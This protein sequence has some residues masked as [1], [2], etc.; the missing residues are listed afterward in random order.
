MYRDDLFFSHTTAHLII[1]I[2][3]WTMSMIVAMI[4]AIVITLRMIMDVAMAWA[5]VSAFA[6]I[7]FSNVVLL[8]T[9][10]DI[11]QLHFVMCVALPWQSSRR[12]NKC[13]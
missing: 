8:K 2:M 4:M 7:L 11:I 10:D 6:M 12:S 9:Y 1:M 5:V 13:D 3:V